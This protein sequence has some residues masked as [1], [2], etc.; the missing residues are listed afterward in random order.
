MVVAVVQRRSGLRRP[1]RPEDRKFSRLA[2]ASRIR[3][4]AIRVAD[5]ARLAEFRLEA[6]QPVWEYHVDDVVIEK[7]L[8]MPHLQNTTQVAFRLLSPTD[9]VSIELQPM[10]HLRPHEEALSDSPA[11]GG[12]VTLG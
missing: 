10:F 7:R 5:V 9:G 1:R 3:T 12:V 6:G 11:R 8:M 2:A 4:P